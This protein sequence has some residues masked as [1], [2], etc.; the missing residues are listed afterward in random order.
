MLKTKTYKYR[1]YPTRK[2]IQ[3]LEHTL[4]ICRI[5]FNS[6]VA[7]RRNHYGR[8]G[9]GLSRIRQQEILVS[10]KRR[11]ADLINVHS[12]VLQDVLFR[13]DR[14]FQSFFRRCR[15]HSGKAGYPRFKGEGQYDSICY[16]QEPG[17]Q[18]TA[19]GLRLSKIGTVKIK[20]HRAI[21]GTVKTCNI[22]RDAGNWYA[23]FSTEFEP[24]LKAV[25]KESIGIDMGIRAFAV[26][27]DGTVI[28]NPKHLR[29]SEQKLV[30]R[31]RRL[32][33]K[34]KGSSNRR[35]ARNAVA[36]H[37]LR[38]RNQ[39]ADFHHKLSYALVAKYG[40]IVVEDLN[41]QGMVKNHSLAKSISDAGWGRFLNY[42]AYKA[43]NAGCKVE[44]V[45]ARLTSIT[46][47]RCGGRVDKTLS[48]RVHICP[49]CCLV[50]DRDHNAAI[51]ILNRAGT[52]RIN[53]C[54][55]AVQQD[56]SVMQEAMSVR[57]W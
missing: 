37:H 38:I 1:L 55:E 44:K 56:P 23:C 21:T 42:L 24:A 40:M 5:L 10:D 6:C 43:E 14:A 54:G 28:E 36:R 22:R 49:Y 8:T 7:D 30:R 13:V 11:V 57:A 25:P 39:R 18:L 2:Q 9:K 20:L 29:K 31:Q 33:S 16:P 51:N 32:S 4:E 26:L 35:K 47:S 12:Q 19:S 17:F 48:D 53:A 15:D 50:M 46:C 52:A 45:S 41:I 3:V 34:K 27:S